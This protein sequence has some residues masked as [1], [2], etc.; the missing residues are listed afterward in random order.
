[1]DSCA[2]EIGRSRRVPKKEVKKARHSAIILHRF[3][4]WAKTTRQSHLT[5][6]EGEF[7]RQRQARSP[8]Y[9]CRRRS[10]GRRKMRFMANQGPCGQTG[11]RKVA[12]AEFRTQIHAAVTD[13]FAELYRDHEQG[14]RRIH[15]D[16]KRADQDRRPRFTVEGGETSLAWNENQRRRFEHSQPEAD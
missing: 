10:R 15:E 12:L 4:G 6:C 3:D 14:G 2:R 9:A 7:S 5:R 11:Q 1:M 16:I 13:Y 8:A